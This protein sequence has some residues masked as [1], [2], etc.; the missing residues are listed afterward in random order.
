[1]KLIDIFRDT[2]SINEKTIVGFLSFS[3]MCF[4]SIFDVLT[5]LY[6]KELVINPI[7]F[8]SFLILTLGAFGI[9]EAGKIFK[10]DVNSIDSKDTLNRTEK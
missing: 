9:A 6:G 2:N 4:I 7:I 8:N 10:K 5:G 1:M 3:M